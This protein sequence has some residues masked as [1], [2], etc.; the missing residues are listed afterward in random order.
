MPDSRVNG[1]NAAAA[2]L[3]P[4]QTTVGYQPQSGP[5]AA[6]RKRHIAQR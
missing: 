4:Q 3:Q 2:E 5:G 6:A 1:S